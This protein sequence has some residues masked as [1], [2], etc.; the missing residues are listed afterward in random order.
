MRRF[1]IS[2]FKVRFFDDDNWGVLETHYLDTNLRLPDRSY[3]KA[4]APL[5]KYLENISMGQYGYVP[6]TGMKFYLV[7]IVYDVILEDL[8]EGDTEDFP[9]LEECTLLEMAERLPFVISNY[10][11][12]PENAGLLAKQCISAKLNNHDIKECISWIERLKNIG[13]VVQDILGKL[14]SIDKKQK[15]LEIKDI[16]SVYTLHVIADLHK[17]L[18]AIKKARTIL[19]R[20][21][22][23]GINLDITYTRLGKVYRLEHDYP[24]AIKFYSKSLEIKDS[25]IPYN[26]LGA[27]YK[28]L[29]KLDEALSS[30]FKA[31]YHQDEHDIRITHTGLGAVYFALED[32]KNGRKHFLQSGCSEE[33]FFRMFYDAKKGD[34]FEKSIECLSLI[35][36]IN[37]NNTKAKRLLENELNARKIYEWKASFNIQK[38]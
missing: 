28:D 25:P 29:N 14:K 16:R 11:K 17:D 30:Y 38:K 20:C 24:N 5:V 37:E 34:L 6:G 32:Y 36:S 8:L 23:I 13:V 31:L 22:V 10:I 26:G 12:I 35:L 7:D 33:Y 4:D 21:I 3:V 15:G 18:N 1:P 27:I 9:R 2:Y 19:E